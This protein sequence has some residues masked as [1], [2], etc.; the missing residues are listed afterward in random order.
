MYVNSFVFSLHSRLYHNRSS[1]LN[2][3]RYL[4]DLIY[5][6]F[7]STNSETLLHRCAV[8]PLSIH[9]LSLC[10]MSR[11]SNIS[12]AR[13]CAI[14]AYKLNSSA[15]LALSFLFTVI[16]RFVT[17]FSTAV[18]LKCF[19]FSIVLSLRFVSEF[20]S[21]PFPCF[22]LGNCLFAN[23]AP[24]VAIRV[25]FFRVSF[26]S[27][28]LTLNTSGVDKFTALVSYRVTRSRTESFRNCRLYNNLLTADRN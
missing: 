13:L 2:F 24:D 18:T 9:H 7:I 14:I 11:E 6:Y 21:L 23:M 22:R 12:F 26:F 17:Y 16:G 10:F 25:S 1:S 28:I 5:R 15:L 3:R 4:L 27:I 20:P 8:H 19:T